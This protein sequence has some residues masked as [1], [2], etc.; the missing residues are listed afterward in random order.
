MKSREHLY[1][2]GRDEPGL[3]SSHLAILIAMCLTLI[4]YLSVKDLV[5]ARVSEERDYARHSD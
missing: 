5:T 4:G 1:S 3:H 2:M